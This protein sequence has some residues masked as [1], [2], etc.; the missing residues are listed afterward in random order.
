MDYK[1]TLLIP[2]TTFE[3]KANLSLKEPEIQKT[4]KQKRIYQKLLDLN[5]NNKEFILHDGP[6]FANGDI[7]IGHALNKILK[8][9]F[10]RYKNLNGYYAKYTPGWDTHGLP[11]EHSMLK[12][13]PN[14]LKDNSPSEFR[15]KCAEYAESYI[16]KQSIGF[17]RLGMLSDFEEKYITYNKEYEANQIKLFFDL[18]KKGHVYK[19]LKPVYWSWS[20]QSA[21][22]EN[23]IEYAEKES[24]SIYT[25][26]KDSTEDFYYV[27]WT[28]T[29]WTLPSNL[30]IAINP[31]F[32]Y[33]LIKY[34]DRNYIIEKNS[35]QR[36]TDKLSWKEFS[37]LR[38][39]TGSELENRTYNH[40]F[41]NRTGK[42]ILANYVS[43]EDGT[44]LVHNA[45]GFG[46]DDYIACK[47]YGIDVYCPINQYGKFDEQI[48]DEE[49]LNLFYEKS[50]PIIMERLKEKN[51]LLF[52]E[53][54]KHSVSHDWRTKKPVMYR[55][56]EQWFISL[57]KSKDLLKNQIDKITTYPSKSKS[58]LLSMVDSRQEWCISRQRI[59]GVPIPF[60]YLDSEPI[61]DNE[62][63]TKII[64]EF[65][66]HG[67]NIWYQKDAN[68]FVTDKYK[69][70]NITK[71]QDIMDVWFD[72]GVSFLTFSSE[73][74][75][76]ADL[77][78]EGSDQFRGWFN[79]SLISSTLSLN[80]SPYKALLSHGFTL[81]GNGKKMSKSLGNVIDPIKICEEYGADVL[82][83]WVSSSD[84]FDDSSISV[85]II[86][87]VAEIYRKIRNSLF[88]FSLGSI[89]DFNYEKDKNLE[90]KQHDKY[91]VSRLNDVYN[92]YIY[93]MNNFNI[94]KSVS[95]ITSL[96]N[97]LSSWYFEICKDS[98]YCDKYN[99]DRRRQIQTTI[100]L[101]LTTC[102]K[103]LNP[104]IP[105]TVEEVYSNLNIENKKESVV[106]DN[107][108]YKI[109]EISLISQQFKLNMDYFF[110]I[111]DLVFKEIENK[112]EQSILSKNIEA[113]IELSLSENDFNHLNLLDLKECLN[114]A[115]CNVI[116]SEATS[117]NLFK[118]EGIKCDRCWN[119][120]D[121]K[122]I[123]K[124][125]C[126]RCHGVVNG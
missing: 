5:K 89:A 7:H 45:P 59:W 50:N 61:I 26:F 82:R 105:H 73:N 17:Q 3:M 79:S 91:I 57:D 48:K 94:T 95:E 119:I 101:V 122:D 63:F 33:S 114:V 69:N 124:D 77:Y 78:L 53:K 117:I 93:N 116:K 12:T 66:E 10:V 41:Y 31:N 102:M 112:R 76:Q 42:I 27:I 98:L 4:W 39:F 47:K 30:A 32:K 54:I 99:S 6:P 92:N 55:A 75:K 60:I 40:S 11:I 113:G 29:P 123:I 65:K 83:L 86:K 107:S 36:V 125:I 68:Y 103:M 115:Y 28:T 81:D 23:E 49:L 74:Q 21:L 37:I 90:L 126:N 70:K 121:K 1:D 46:H 104:I 2:K 58:R 109:D 34:L 24:D 14:L 87:Q 35:V 51:L 8:D 38:E 84:Y 100:Y 25:A 88:R 43:N 110:K 16:Q 9:I 13:H 85:S 71:E 80:Q 67:S 108:I 118:Y 19:A 56:T 62:I 111:K 44:G 22:A 97:E 52:S 18:V 15:N 20:S 64:N 106:L 120:V 72:S 96:L